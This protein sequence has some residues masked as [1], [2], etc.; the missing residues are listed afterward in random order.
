M[1]P[2]PAIRGTLPVSQKRL[3]VSAKASAKSPAKATVV[4]E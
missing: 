2:R 3:V 4:I 1:A